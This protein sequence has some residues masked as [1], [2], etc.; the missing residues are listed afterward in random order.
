MASKEKIVAVVDIGTTKVVALA[1]VKTNDN[2]VDVIAYAKTAAK[3]IKRGVVLNID[4]VVGV[5]N[6]VINQVEE[7]FDGEVRQLDV[8][9]AGQ[10]LKTIPFKCSREIAEGATVS[11]E[12]ISTLIKEAV[13]SP[14]DEEHVIY[15]ILP[16]QFAVDGEP[17]ITNPVGAAGKR[18]DAEFHLLTAPEQYKF[19]VEMVL[20]KISIN[21][22]RMVMSPLAAAEAVLTEDEKEAGV[23]LVDIGGGITKSAIYSDGMLCYCSVVPFG[24]NAVT[25]DIKEGCAIAPRLAEQLKVQFGKAM[26]DF[27]E[28]E[29]VVTIPGD[30]GWEPKE[31]SFKSLAFIIQARLEEIIDSLYYQLENSGYLDKVGAGIVLTGGTANLPNL[32]QLVRY[33]TGLDARP[34]R[35]VINLAHKI[36]ELEKYEYHTALG[37][38][39]FS[40]ED[41]NH[42]STRRKK[43]KE[44]KGSNAFFLNKVNKMKEKV[45][46]GFIDFFDDAD[47]EM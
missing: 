31:I 1:G 21:L 43:R 44:K 23:I 20:D 45:S 32:I 29:K 14:V 2:K 12:D 39:K 22:R 10:H 16:Y 41:I 35:P 46:Q 24:G 3:G 47:I 13:N 27:A 37:L 11:K 30:N 5:V 38:L 26:G 36:P 8:A 17:G 7:A 28:E 9:I 4:E 25:R 40:L 33:R 18:L 42:E 6:D 15:H 34:G 19:N